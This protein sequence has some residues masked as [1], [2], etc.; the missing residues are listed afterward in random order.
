LCILQGIQGGLEKGGGDI[1]TIYAV[2]GIGY[3]RSFWYSFWRSFCSISNKKR[4]AQFWGVL[5]IY[6]RYWV[7]AQFLAQFLAH[8]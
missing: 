6:M 5:K 2:L 8:I 3:W 4:L 1:K 7:L